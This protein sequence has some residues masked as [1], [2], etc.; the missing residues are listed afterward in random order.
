MKKSLKHFWQYFRAKLEA[1]IWI[2]GLLLMA[3]MSPADSHASLCPLSATGID[4]CPGCGLGQSVSYLARGNFE[5]SF[6]AHPLGIF[7]VLVLLF[8]I[9]QIFRKPVFYY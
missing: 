6:M 4:F 7:A 5:A 3:F 8:R 2:A 9:I 1:F